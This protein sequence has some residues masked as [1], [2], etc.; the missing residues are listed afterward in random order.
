MRRTRLF[1]FSLTCLLVVLF[2]AGCGGGSSKTQTQTTGTPVMLQ[3]GDA[4]NDQIVRFSLTVN[5]IT[6]TGTGRS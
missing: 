2:V 6:L 5:S 4:M 1:L 3:T